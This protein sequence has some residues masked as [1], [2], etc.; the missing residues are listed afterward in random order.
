MNTEEINSQ[1]LNKQM[2]EVKK[3]SNLY[4][5]TTIFIMLAIIV[6]GVVFG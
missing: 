3:S 5:G 1:Q 4:I 6:I 2:A